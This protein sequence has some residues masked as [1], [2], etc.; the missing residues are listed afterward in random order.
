M[1]TG[2]INK[3]QKISRVQQDK[4]GND[5]VQVTEHGWDF[6]I[7][8]NEK[9]EEKKLTSASKTDITYTLYRPCTNI[10]EMENKE[11]PCKISSE[12]GFAIAYSEK[13]QLVLHLNEITDKKRF[14]NTRSIHQ[15][16]SKYQ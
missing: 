4:K 13:L 2:C 12:G 7:H 6:G 8:Y 10:E 15:N 3:P 5:I 9:I 16:T 1:G 14:T 11:M